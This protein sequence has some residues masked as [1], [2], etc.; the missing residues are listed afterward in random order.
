MS[1]GAC[2]YVYVLGRRISWEEE[3]AEELGGDHEMGCEQRGCF[4]LRISLEYSDMTCNEPV[5]GKSIDFLSLH[6]ILFGSS[7]WH[8][9]SFHGCCSGTVGVVLRSR[10]SPLGRALAEQ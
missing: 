4:P 8:L 6:C 5:F 3:Q 2:A 7:F 1:L 9:D 10:K